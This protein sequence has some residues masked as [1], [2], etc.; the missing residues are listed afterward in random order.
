MRYIFL[1]SLL[2]SLAFSNIDNISFFEADFQQNITDDKGKVLSYRGHI[3]AMKPQYALWSYKVPVLK[4]IYIE[5][6]KLT[7]IEPELEQVIIKHIN[8]DFDFFS[9]IE[10]AKK[11]DNNTYTANFKETQFKIRI[12]DSKKIESI[13]YK[14]E[15]ENDVK[16]EFK[17]QI[18]NRKIDKNEFLPIIPFEYDI[19]R[20]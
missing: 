12:S 2:S 19:I 6:R 15:F 13:S 20:D 10:H 18:Q 14:D 16:I 3:K 9:M 17:K 1:L 11:I 4:D 7:I 5:P 8:S